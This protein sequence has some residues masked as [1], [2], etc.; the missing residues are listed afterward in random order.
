MT[1]CRITPKKGK[2]FTCSDLTQENIKNLNSCPG[3]KSVKRI[4]K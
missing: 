1:R 3:I 2:S 4:K